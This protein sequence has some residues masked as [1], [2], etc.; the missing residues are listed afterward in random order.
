MEIIFASGNKGK[1]TEVKN[2]FTSIEGLKI[3]PLCDLDDLPEIIEDGQTIEENAFIKAR[4]I[5]E[6][7][8][9]PV[10]SDDT[11][12]IV[13]QLGGEPGVHA[14]RYA[15]ENCTYDD[16]NRKLLSE[17]SPF[18]EPHRAKFLCCAVYFDHTRHISVL[19]EMA[20]EIIREKRGVSGFGYDPVF[21][22]EGYDRTLAEMKLEEKNR[23]S[24]R[25]K[26][27][28]E[29]KRILKLAVI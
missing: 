3:I 24:H 12:L 14:A 28:N 20:G 18:K 5:F 19:G 17:L 9:R 10:I 15:G 11:G 21:L 13:D 22:P 7:Y 25:A 27:F 16:N 8:G 2:L 29:L 4:V 26:A 1:I 6:K 23:I